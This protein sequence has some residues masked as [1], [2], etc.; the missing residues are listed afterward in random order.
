MKNSKKLTVY[1]LKG[2]DNCSMKQGMIAIETLRRRK[3]RTVIRQ[4][5]LSVFAP[6]NVGAIDFGPCGS[7]IGVEPRFATASRH[8]AL[9]ETGMARATAS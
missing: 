7:H 8:Q 4:R 5:A 6:R 2:I 3:G 1:G 9:H